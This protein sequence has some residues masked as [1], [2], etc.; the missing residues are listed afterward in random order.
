[1]LST[2]A[3]RTIECLVT[4][5]K[6]HPFTVNSSGYIRSTT[7]RTTRTNLPCCPLAVKYGSVSN[8]AA[9]LDAVDAGMDAEVAKLISLAAENDVASNPEIVE[10][11]SILMG[12]SAGKTSASARSNGL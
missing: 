9:V 1:M 11:R 8:V 4:E 2:N 5:L 10:A 6:G 12:C 3:R 7:K